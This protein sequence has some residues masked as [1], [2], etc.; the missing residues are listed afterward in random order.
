[1]A[2]MPPPTNSHG[3]RGVVDESSAGSGSSDASG[4]GGS[5]S[6]ARGV[7]EGRPLAVADA[8]LLARAVGEVVAIGSPVPLGGTEG[9]GETGGEVGGEVG[10]GVGGS[11]GAIVGRGVRVGRGVGPGVDVGF[12]VGDAVG[13]G[14]TTVRVGPASVGSE[15][16]T[17]SARKVTGQEP[18]G[19]VELPA[20]VPPSAVPD[21]RA[22]VTVVPATSAQTELAAKPWSLVYATLNANAVARV[23]VVGVTDPPL[24]VF[25]TPRVCPAI[26]R[27]AIAANS[28]LDTSRIPRRRP[29]TPIAPGFPAGASH[30]IGSLTCARPRIIPRPGAA[31][32]VAAGRR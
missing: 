12:G 18:A 24:R 23:P 16:C 28:A 22:S 30:L 15:P 27:A 5:A 32:S 20:K 6:V 14:P 13:V 2:D 25:P 31:A 21:T 29:D 9:G 26:A 11:V 3:M 8:A 1:M 10:T 4:D 7:I 17:A 19:R